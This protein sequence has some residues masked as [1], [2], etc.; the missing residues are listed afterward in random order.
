MKLQA[1]IGTSLLLLSAPLALAA[2]TPAPTNQTL[3][4]PSPAPAPS[5]QN[6]TSPT[7]QVSPP[8]SPT[9]S[10]PSSK[11][12]KPCRTYIRSNTRNATEDVDV[13]RGLGFGLPEYEVHAVSR[14][15]GAWGRV[16]ELV[17]FLNEEILEGLGMAEEEIEALRPLGR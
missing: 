9:S 6:T 16:Y 11:S 5:A 14:I 17:P 10:T 2:S 7:P 13:L 3:S 15:E 12:A 4:H 8:P 1:V